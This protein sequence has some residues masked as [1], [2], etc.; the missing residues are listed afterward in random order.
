MAVILCLP[1]SGAADIFSGEPWVEQ[2]SEIWRGP[3]EALAER[4]GAYICIASGQNP[5]DLI[6]GSAALWLHEL[7]Q[8]D[9]ACASG[10]WST[11]VFEPSALSAVD[12]LRLG[13]TSLVAAHTLGAGHELTGDDI[14]S[15]A[16]GHGIPVALKHEV[17]GKKLCY[18]LTRNQ[19]ITFGNIE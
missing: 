2:W 18:P 19:E 4:L 6:G 10:R 3:R 16:G 8:L 9:E 7:D 11:V 5:P 13:R 15:V 17:I 14:L 1:P 12:A